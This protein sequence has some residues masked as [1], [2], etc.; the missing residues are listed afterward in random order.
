[1]QAL[2]TPQQDGRTTATAPAQQHY[3]FRA[4]PPQQLLPLLMLPNPLLQ[5]NLKLRMPLRFLTLHHQRHQAL[6]CLG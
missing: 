1:M 6:S 5:A 4:T 2:A 3:A